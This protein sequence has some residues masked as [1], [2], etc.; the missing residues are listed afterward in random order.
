MEGGGGPGWG[1]AGGGG[2]GGSTPV[3]DND[4]HEPVTVPPGRLNIS[5]LIHPD[6]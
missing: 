5:E 6:T 4:V 2:G 1:G 3:A